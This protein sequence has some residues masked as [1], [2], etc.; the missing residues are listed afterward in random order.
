M[1]ETGDRQPSHFDPLLPV[2]SS[3]TVIRGDAERSA[4]ASPGE[5]F[6]YVS[7]GERTGR[8][9]RRH[10]L[11]DVSPRQFRSSPPKSRAVQV[12]RRARITAG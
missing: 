4:A 11:C 2:G 6:I 7:A 5:M 8:G 10:V 9:F 12:T 3:E 1:A